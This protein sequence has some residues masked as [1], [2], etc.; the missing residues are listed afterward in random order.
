VLNRSLPLPVSSRTTA[1]RTLL[2]VFQLEQLLE[3]CLRAWTV[4]EPCRH[5]AVD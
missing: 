3:T 1:H 5:M 2:W 4:Y